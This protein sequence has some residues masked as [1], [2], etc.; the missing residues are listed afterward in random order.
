RR[1]S[2]GPA[3]ML[4]RWTSL[5]FGSLRAACPMDFARLRLAALGFPDGL[6][7]PSARCAR[8]ARWTSLAFGS[9]RAA[10]PS[11]PVTRRPRIGLGSP[12]SGV[13]RL[14]PRDNAP[15]IR[16]L[17]T[18]PRA[19]NVNNFKVGVGGND[20]SEEEGRRGEGERRRSDH[21][22][23]AHEGGGEEVQRRER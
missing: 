19:A 1:V 12:K 16:P 5:A 13:F 10:C 15:M 11:E 2:M 8:L 20:G 22:E 23:V 17:R 4:A 21:L 14:S 18:P 6:R 7:S 9:L 3:R